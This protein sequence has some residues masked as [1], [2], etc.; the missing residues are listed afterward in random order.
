MLSSTPRQCMAARTTSGVVWTAPATKPGPIHHPHVP[1][2]VDSVPPIAGIPV[3]H[4]TSPRRRAPDISTAATRAQ[5]DGAACR[6]RRRP[7]R[8]PA[9]AM[10]GRRELQRL[11]EGRC[12]CTRLRNRTRLL[13]RQLSLGLATADR[14]DQQ[15]GTEDQRDQGLGSRAGEPLRGE[16]QHP[17]QWRVVAADTWKRH[18]PAEVRTRQALHVDPGARVEGGIRLANHVDRLPTVKAVRV[19]YL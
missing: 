3:R 14:K 8:T 15:G 19:V 6:P 9:L 7:A 16:N 2:R 17:L 13:H 11:L 18:F 12:R 1:P 10:R 4:T 5:V